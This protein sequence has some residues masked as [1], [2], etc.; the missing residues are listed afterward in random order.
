MPSTRSIIKSAV[1]STLKS[2]NL[3][4]GRYDAVTDAYIAV[5]QFAR[6]KKHLAVL[7]AYPEHAIG[8]IQHIEDACSQLGQD[9]FALTQIGTKQP[10]YFVEFGATDGKSLSNTYLLEK[11]FGWT[12]ILAEPA[13]VWHSALRSNRSCHIDQDCVWSESGKTL[14]FLETDIAE[15]STIRSFED[16]DLNASRRAG[17][18][19][20]VSTVSFVDLLRR[21]EAPSTIEYLSIDT[22]GSEYEILRDFDFDT[23]RFKVISC[24]HNYSKNR[25]AIRSLLERH[26]YQAVRPDLSDFDDWYVLNGTAVS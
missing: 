12:G 19:Y 15:L 2:A 26:G 22:E 25:V 10:G 5:G 11:Y 9:I 14:D 16:D 21:Y 18:S 24:E 17:G 8:I 20:G 13:R 6:T 1:H 7:K 3:R 23:Y 4:V